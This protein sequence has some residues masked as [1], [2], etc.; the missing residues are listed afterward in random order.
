MTLTTIPKSQDNNTTTTTIEEGANNNIQFHQLH[1][2]RVSK[3]DEET[4]ADDVV[5]A[6][7]RA[8]NLHDE[9]DVVEIAHFLL[10]EVGE[11][12]ICVHTILT[13]ILYIT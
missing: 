8:Q 6:I 3:L 10:E 1:S 9:H 2:Q 7:K 11:L 12:Y 4:T 13:D 5:K